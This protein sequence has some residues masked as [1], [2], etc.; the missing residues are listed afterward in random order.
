MSLNFSSPH[1]KMSSG[2]SIRSFLAASVNSASAWVKP[3]DT[4]EDSGCSAFVC[5]LRSAWLV[6]TTGVG[7]WGGTSNETFLESPEVEPE[8]EPDDALTLEVGPSVRMA[9]AVPTVGVLRDFLR[10]RLGNLGILAGSRLSLK[11]L[12]RDDLETDAI[13][14]QNRLLERFAIS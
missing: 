3:G 1:C 7:I 12:L 13:L 5:N 8:A 10:E 6:S 14:G 4:S 11:V 9:D 2:I